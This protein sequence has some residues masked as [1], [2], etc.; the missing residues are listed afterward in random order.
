M[1]Q[2][3]IIGEAWGRHEEEAGEPFVGPT[4]RKLNSMLS[5]AG[6]AR[7]ECYLTN[8]F[9]L[10]PKPTNDVSNLCGPKEMG[11]AKW[12]ALSVGNYV[13]KEHHPELIRLENEIRSINPNLIIS[14]G[15]TPLW[16][17]TRGTAQIKKVRGTLLESWTGHKVLPTYHPAAGFRNS[18]FFPLI[19]VDLSKAR[20]E[21]EF[22]E[23]R[24][25]SREVWIAE[26]PSDLIE[27]ENRFFNSSPIA[28]DIETQDGQITCIGFAPSEKHALVIPF[29]SFPG[30]YW[31]SLSDESF[32]WRW[33]RRVLA[34][35]H[36]VG[37][38]FSYDAHYLW[39]RYGIPSPGWRDDTMLLHH[40]LHP[41]LEKSL[42]FM[43]SVYTSEPA[44]KYM[45][46]GSTLK[47]ED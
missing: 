3:I 2:I 28:A 38:N 17:L 27:F 25:P 40:A 35:Y 11:L 18:T 4:G 13:L 7:S 32:V 31:N 1:H 9:N 36:I 16:F 47:K 44:W 34:D 26:H 41:E 29:I 6:I 33:V 23:I 42:G 12:P 15:A 20:A 30:N 46:K 8:V 14:L 19:Q 10:R 22:P 39:S 24:R 43:G 45:R 37:Q 5:I 21:A